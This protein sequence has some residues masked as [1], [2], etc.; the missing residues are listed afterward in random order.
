MYRVLIGLC[1]GLFLVSCTSRRV[2]PN[3]DSR[4]AIDT[5]YMNNVMLIQPKIDSLCAQLYDSIYVVA[6]DSILKER[7]EEMNALIK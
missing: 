3:R 1:L 5:I 7:Q 6:V 2:Q 4:R